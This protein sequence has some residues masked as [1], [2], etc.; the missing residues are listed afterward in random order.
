[1]KQERFTIAASILQ[2]KQERCHVRFTIAKTKRVRF[3]FAASILQMKQERCHVRF[4][5]A[6]SVP[7]SDET[8]TGICPLIGTH[9]MSRLL[10]LLLQHWRYGRLECF[11]NRRNYFCKPTFVVLRWLEVVIHKI[12]ETR[13]PLAEIV[14]LKKYVE[15]MV[16]AL[17]VGL[18]L[19]KSLGPS[20]GP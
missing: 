9:S 16:R 14:H 2:M 8:R 6:A 1:M 3:T 11:F 5:I 15:L 12:C 19:A 7:T 18:T 17:T 13:P 20:G 4:T 10:H